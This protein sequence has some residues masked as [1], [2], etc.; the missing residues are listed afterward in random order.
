MFSHQFNDNI[1]LHR[2]DDVYLF[3]CVSTSNNNIRL[4]RIDIIRSMKQ[5][6]I[7]K[8]MRVYLNDIAAEILTSEHSFTSSTSASSSSSAIV[9]I[10][11]LLLLLFLFVCFVYKMFDIM[12]IFFNLFK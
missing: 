10:L 11:F 6:I 1:L 7:I 8:L 3:L 12:Y 9:F 5:N 2:P 4:L